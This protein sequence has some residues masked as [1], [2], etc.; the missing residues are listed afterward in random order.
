MPPLSSL[1]DPIPAPA[2][3]RIVISFRKNDERALA[4]RLQDTLGMDFGDGNVLEG[5]EKLIKPGDDFLDAIQ[6]GI[7][8]SNALVV[9][10]GAHWND[11]AWLSNAHDYD[12]IAIETAI[13]ERK[14]LIPILVNG[15]TLPAELPE[16][17]KSL[18]RRNAL[19]MSDLSFRDDVKLLLSTLKGV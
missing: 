4:G 5:V 14:K 7:K 19:T 15:A 8:A 9:V 13:R 18:A 12:R 2:K 17:L 16:E 3:Q 6:D 11:E 10:I 1:V